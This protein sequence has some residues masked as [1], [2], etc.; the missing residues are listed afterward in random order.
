[1]KAPFILELLTGATLK[2]ELVRIRLLFLS[3]KWLLSFIYEDIELFS[4]FILLFLDV[5]GCSDLR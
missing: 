2:N 1:M 3:K 5:L 4:I